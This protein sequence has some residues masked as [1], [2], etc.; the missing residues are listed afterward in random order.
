[1]QPEAM[2]PTNQNDAVLTYDSINQVILAVVKITE[3][4][5]EQAR[6][7]LET[8]AYDAGANRWTKMN[9]PQE[10]A[11][12]GSRARVLTFAPELNVALLENRTHPP[13]GEQ[14]QQVWTY[15]FGEPGLRVPPF[16]PTELR[17]TTAAESATLTWKRNASSVED[18]YLIYRGTGAKPW[19]VDYQH[20]AIVDA[21]QTI[22]QDRDVK[23]GTVYFYTV[24]AAAGNDRTSADS[25]KVR[26]QPSLVEDAVV[27]VLS[28][29]QVELSWQ[30]PVGDDIAGYHVERAVVEVFT[31]DQLKRLKS[32]TPP[33]PEP[34]I[35]AIRRIGPFTRLTDGPVKGTTFND[36]T[37]DLTK[38]QT[39]D[40]EPVYERTFYAEH[41]DEN[42]Q[43]YRFAVYAYRVRAVNALGVEGG[44]SPA[45]FTI[46]SA[47]QFVFSRED[48]TTC[49]LK[50]SANPEQGLRGY[51]V[52]R[53]D[54]RWDTDPISRLT[55][56]PI[57]ELTYRDPTAGEAFRR[58]H[59]VA[60]DG[61]GQE[62]F[63][64]APVW[65]MREW[66][67]FYE[68]FVGEWHQ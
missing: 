45:F 47:P 60:V 39:V 42:G 28:P 63:P 67:K 43:P 22:Y 11:P 18:R 5:D 21:R 2:P 8:W 40:G 53:M 38:P 34:S 51:R 56:D 48:G 9:P 52:Y 12:S 10:P 58:Y 7:R 30:P 4:E 24:R 49:H 25:M 17:V 16:P 13:Q 46:P 64:S 14:E 66:R 55:A 1:M 32:H 26:T 15:R 19:E 62:G 37:V 20:V 6:H 61:I 3:G 59:V 23:P 57:T 35:G 44:A 33:L 31:E 36:T 29:R 50:W 54:G 41:L 68:P 27:S 65:F